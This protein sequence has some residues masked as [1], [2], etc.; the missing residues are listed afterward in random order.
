[1]LIEN[2]TERFFHGRDYLQLMSHQHR[3]KS[4]GNEDFDHNQ[5]ELKNLGFLVCKVGDYK[6]VM[7]MKK[8]VKDQRLK[9]DLVLVLVVGG[10]FCYI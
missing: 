3:N 5:L 1:M 6:E 9:K 8:K 2:L 7:K 4:S 10:I